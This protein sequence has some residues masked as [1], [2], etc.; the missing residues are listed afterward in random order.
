MEKT[1]ANLKKLK[2]FH[3][4]SYGTDIDRAIKALEQGPRTEVD[5]E[6]IS[7]LSEL[8]SQYNLFDE[9]ERKY[10]EALSKA[11][12]SLKGVEREP[13]EDVIGRAEAMTEIMMFTGNVKS[14]EDV[15]IKVS[16]AVQL[17]RE[18]PPVTPKPKSEQ[19]I[20]EELNRLSTYRASNSKTD[21][22]S[23]KAVERV[24]NLVFRGSR[25]KEPPRTGH[26]IV[27]EYGIKHCPFCNAINNTVYDSYCANCGAEMGDEKLYLR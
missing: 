4:G 7:T 12:K 16:D 11:I 10:Y 19:E 8:R 9:V 23:L 27:D 6:I 3:N 20:R 2:S 25:D 14:D 21:L 13:C 5:W 1:I 24:L 15:Y 17:L 26:W 22:V 18:L